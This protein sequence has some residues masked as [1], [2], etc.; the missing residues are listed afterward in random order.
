MEELIIESSLLL[1][2]HRLIAPQLRSHLCTCSKK[3]FMNLYSL[4]FWSKMNLYSRIMDFNPNLYCKKLY[5]YFFDKLLKNVMKFTQL[6]F[7]K[8]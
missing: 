3:S 4:F 2:C 8:T 6:M 7:I 1:T 5:S